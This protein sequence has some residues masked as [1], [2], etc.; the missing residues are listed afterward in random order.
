MQVYSFSKVLLC[1]ADS[2]SRSFMQLHM[3]AHVDALAICNDGSPG[4]YY[5][6]PGSPSNSTRLVIGL[7]SVNFTCFVCSTTARLIVPYCAE[8]SQ[9]D[10]HG[11]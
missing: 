9:A 10:V 3:V 4:A 2:V 1:S 7:D 6:R 11:D 8:E 5:H